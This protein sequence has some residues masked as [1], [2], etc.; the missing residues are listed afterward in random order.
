MLGLGGF[1]G[2]INMSY[3][4]NS[5]VHNTHWIPAHFHLIFGG[6]V[7]IM[8]MAVAY[9][10]WP[11]VT[12][13]APPRRLVRMQLWTWCVGMLITTLPW[14]VAGL[15]GQARRVSSF[16][17]NQPAL[18][19]V[20]LL[21]EISVLGG[22]V[23]LLSGLGFAALLISWGQARE[24][25]PTWPF[26]RSLDGDRP[27]AAALNGFRAWNALLLLAMVVCY[28]WPVPQFLVAPRETAPLAYPAGSGL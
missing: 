11:S 23:L 12:G 19:S 24:A 1:S 10:I 2:T 26:A 8:Y 21:A 25:R 20:A 16:D 27:L 14:H 18:R 17:Y 9:E 28:G 13:Y 6:A 3:A 22:A 15:L 5:M 4:M 7:V